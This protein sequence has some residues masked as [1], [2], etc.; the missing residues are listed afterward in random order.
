MRL[1][2]F[3]IRQVLATSSSTNRMWASFN[4]VSFIRSL[5]PR[6]ATISGHHDR[7]CEVAYRGE[8]ERRFHGLGQEFHPSALQRTLSRF[9]TAHESGEK[10]NGN[11]PKTRI[12]RGL[13]RDITTALAWHIDIE[14]HDRRPELQRSGERAS[15]FIHD[16]HFVLA[17]VLKDHAGEPRKIYIV[18][19][20][21]YT[22]LAHACIRAGRVRSGLRKLR[23]IPHTRWN[24]VRA[25]PIIHASWCA[26]RWTPYGR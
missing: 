8:E 26:S 22:P 2:K 3:V 18:I 14:Q 7:R 20:N 4:V 19:H 9:L 24:S 16:H 13:A 11:F 15:G 17:G 6:S 12:Q 1:R 5:F 25:P 23:T 21:Q 10:E